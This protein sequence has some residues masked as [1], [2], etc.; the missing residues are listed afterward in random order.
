MS[1]RNRKTYRGAIAPPA[2]PGPP[3]RIGPYDPT[4]RLSTPV[5][6]R[7]DPDLVLGSRLRAGAVLNLL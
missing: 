3:L 4:W 7:C 5:V 6:R 1:V 2:G